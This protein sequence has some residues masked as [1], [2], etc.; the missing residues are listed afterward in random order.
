MVVV[1]EDP[2]DSIVAEVVVGSNLEEG[3][4]DTVVGI[5]VGN[6]CLEVDLVELCTT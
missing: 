1:E 5:L 4:V 6:P 2:V 3:L